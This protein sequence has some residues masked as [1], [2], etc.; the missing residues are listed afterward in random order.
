MG[1]DPFVLWVHEDQGVSTLRSWSRRLRRPNG[2][3]V[4]GSTARGRRTRSSSHLSGAYRLPIK[5]IPYDGGSTVAKGISPASKIM[6]S[7]NNR[8]KTCRESATFSTAA[9]LR[10]NGAGPA[11]AEGEGLRASPYYNQRAEWS[12]APGMCRGGGG[13]LPRFLHHDI[14]EGVAGLPAVREP[15]AALDERRR[16]ESC[17]S[18]QIEN[19]KDTPTRRVRRARG[20]DDALRRDRD[21][22]GS[23]SLLHLPDAI[24]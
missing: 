4:M 18:R 11:D 21:G 3:W 9:G 20:D 17:W 12:R 6:A 13:I 22:G 16:A 23:C 24:E 14:Y 5:Y 1:V 10:T 7:V 2:E 8:P 19:H 15:L